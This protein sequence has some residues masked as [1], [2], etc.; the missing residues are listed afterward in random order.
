MALVASWYNGVIDDIN[1]NNRQIEGQIVSRFMKTG[2]ADSLQDELPMNHKS[3]FAPLLKSMKRVNLSVP[4]TMHVPE[5]LIV[6]CEGHWSNFTGMV[7]L[8][9]INVTGLH[10]DELQL[11]RQT[12]KAM[13]SSQAQC[14]TISTHLEICT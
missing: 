2:L 7:T 6:E 8:Q 13:Y 11:L 3:H 14:L 9:K 4:E 1:T 10:S 12:Y 5:A